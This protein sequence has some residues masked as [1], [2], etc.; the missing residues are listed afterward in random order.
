MTRELNSTED[1]SASSTGNKGTGDTFESLIERYGDNYRWFALGAVGLGSFG[2]FIMSTSV[3]VAIPDVM[4]A[5]GIGQDVA[6]WLSTSFL[7][8]STVSMLVAAW[9]IATWGLRLSYLLPSLLFIGASVLA[10]LSNSIEL[11]ILA[12]T[13]QGVASGIFLP[14]ASYVTTRTFPP[15]KQG[16]GM[17]IFGI[18]AV[19]GPAI[20]PYTGGLLIDSYGWKSVF[21]LPLPML[22]AS[23]PLS[24]MFL[25]EHEQE[26]IKQPLDWTSIGLL[27]VGLTLLLNTATKG[28]DK[29]W[30]SDYTYIGFTLS[31][32]AALLFVWRQKKISNPLMDLRLYQYPAFNQAAIISFVYGV[33]LYSGMY[34]VPLFLQ[35][36]QSIT[37]TEAGLTLL[38]GG[39]MMAVGLLIGGALSDRV[40]P[41]LV[42]FAGLILLIYSFAVMHD[43]NRFTSLAMMAWWVALGRI[44]MAVMMPAINVAAFS[45]LPQNLLS[46]ASGTTNFL[47]QMSGAIGVN[48]ISV[49]LARQTSLHTEHIVATQ[50]ADNPQ[51]RIMLEELIPSLHQSGVDQSLHEPIAGWILTSELYRQG[52][53]L[54]F[55][56]AFVATALISIVALIPAWLLKRAMAKA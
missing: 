11:M 30:A 2:A 34:T 10:M 18:L 8:A 22:I 1:S 12:R 45:S 40:P 52:L 6:Q 9:C 48:L 53:T 38:P 13:L 25:P 51:T 37:P 4:G 32:V 44:G 26:Q 55:Q 23:L 50:Q 39:L 16:I 43:A 33:V 47:R 19:M 20:G 24:Q 36:V 27:S 46:Q 3:N 54:A 14:L 17:A 7:A 21:L 49:Y 31:A 42:M 15:E 41:Y 5:Y 29:G 28:Q 56:D 35:S